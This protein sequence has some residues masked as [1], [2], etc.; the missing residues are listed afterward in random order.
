VPVFGPGLLL[1]IEN[2]GIQ[3]E[4]VDGKIYFIRDLP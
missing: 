2:R 1:V 4:T 3:D